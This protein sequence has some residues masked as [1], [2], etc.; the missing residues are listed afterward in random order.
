MSRDL[1]TALARECS[2]AR[3]PTLEAAKATECRRMW[4]RGRGPPAARQ[5]LD[6]LRGRMT[7]GAWRA[8][9]LGVLRLSDDDARVADE[10]AALHLDD[11]D[12]HGWRGRSFRSR[13]RKQGWLIDRAVPTIA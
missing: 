4:I 3:R 6:P 11:N 7:L 5:H 8:D 2:G 13:F 10:A 1:S 12:P 9:A